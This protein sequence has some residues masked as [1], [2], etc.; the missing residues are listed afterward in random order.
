LYCCLSFCT[1]SSKSV[2]S[3]LCC[4]L[5]LS[6]PH[7]PTLEMSSRNRV[8]V[9]CVVGAALLV[10]AASQSGLGG[11]ALVASPSGSSDTPPSSSS[12]SAEP[13]PLS[14]RVV[15]QSAASPVA[16][17]TASSASAASSSLPVSPFFEGSLFTDTFLKSE[18]AAGQIW[19]FT[20]LARE[21]SAADFVCP[22][23]FS[24]SEH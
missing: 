3:T 21:H 7:Q 9:I 10:I 14:S 8:A 22:F 5:L 13:A 19:Q 24:L 11:L 23:F 4:S 15:L 18:D 1:L 17:S 6:F 12:H 20:S 16:D 2:R